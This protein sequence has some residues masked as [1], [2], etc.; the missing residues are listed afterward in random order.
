MKLIKNLILVVS[1]IAKFAR[2]VDKR[3]DYLLTEHGKSVK[4]FNQKKGC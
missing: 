2:V 4:L 1:V 3:G